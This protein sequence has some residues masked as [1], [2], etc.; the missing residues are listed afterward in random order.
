MHSTGTVTVAVDPR[1]TPDF[2]ILPDVAYDF[3]ETTP[4]LHA[5]AV[6]ADAVYFGTLAQRAPTSRETLAR[7]LD[8]APNALKILDLN[9]RKDCHSNETIQGSLERAN[10][11]KLNEDEAGVLARQFRFPDPFIPAFCDFI[12][13]RFPLSHVVVTLGERGAFAASKEGER[14]Y[15]PGRRVSNLVDTCGSGDA[16]TAGFVHELL[17]GKPLP[18]CLGRGNILGALVT[19]QPGA[20][21]PMTENAD[22]ASH[23]V[24]DPALARFEPF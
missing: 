11:L 22:L 6:A 8:A 20:T 19:G 18:D 16:F 7:L 14:V 15:V 2:T 1:G 24:S 9:L 23:P 3:I 10:L 13:H 5:A 4:E 21:T 12:L 17:G